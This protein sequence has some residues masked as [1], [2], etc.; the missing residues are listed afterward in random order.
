VKTHFQADTMRIICSQG[1]WTCGKIAPTKFGTFD[2]GF[3]DWAKSHFQASKMK[4]IPTRC[5]VP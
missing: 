3:H 1:A 2:R 5:E 4:N